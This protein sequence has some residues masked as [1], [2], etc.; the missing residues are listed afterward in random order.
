MQRSVRK[1]LGS[2]PEASL[3]LVREQAP[4]GSRAKPGSAGEARRRWRRTWGCR[5][6]G[7]AAAASGKP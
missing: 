2:V 4:K 7:L 3:G 1:A 6:R 5:H